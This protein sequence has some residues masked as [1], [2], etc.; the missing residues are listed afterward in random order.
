MKDNVILVLDK[1]EYAKNE[2]EIEKLLRTK[3]A[4]ARIVYTEYED[5]LIRNV[6]KIKI[7]GS[8]L[9]HMLYWI[10]SFKYTDSIMKL[11]DESD[12]ICINPIVGMF[13]GLK[14]KRKKHVICLCG[15]LFEPKKNKIYY[16][17]RK[18]FV[19][20]C[21]LGINKIIVYS[22]KEVK[23]YNEIFGT[24]NFTFLRYG[25]DYNTN[26]EYK[27]S[28]PQKYIFSGGGSNRDYKTLFEAYRKVK[29]KI[30]IPLVVATLPK[31]V[32]GLDCSE[33]DI[34]TDVVLET[35]GDLIKKSEV[36][37]LSLKDLELSAGHQVILQGLKENVPII[38]NNIEAVRDYV[39]D[40]NV[41]FYESKNSDDLA[42]KLEKYFCFSNYSKNNIIESNTEFYKKNY[43]FSA[44]LK[45]IID[46]I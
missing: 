20:R 26:F 35:F 10:K 27:G 36:M 25:I 38:V 30:N 19:E 1:T 15:F 45:R 11:Y 7:I 31:C 24:N 41:I 17:L 12:I 33:V 23:Y 16:N 46:T 6:R 14:N 13:L 37:V 9:Q 44:L 3:Y 28:L 18:A 29:N 22:N 2:S 39:S 5:K 40:K 34:K 32:E 42:A 4:N 43:T 21:F 8:P